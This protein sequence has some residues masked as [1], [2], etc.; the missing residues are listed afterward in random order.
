MTPPRALVFTLALALAA[1]ACAPVNLA[2]IEARGSATELVVKTNWP[3]ILGEIQAGKGPALS[4]ALAAAEVPQ[5]ERPARILQL[6]GDLPG[7]TDN[8]GALIAA[9]VSYGG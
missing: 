8:L 6:Q 1:P 5:A 2:D 7:F 9:L 3:A 4:N